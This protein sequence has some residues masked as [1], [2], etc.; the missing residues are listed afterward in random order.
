MTNEYIINTIKK[1]FEK[2][3]Y[4]FFTKGKYNVNLFGIRS[5]TRKANKFDDWF[6]LVYKDRHDIWK[7]WNCP[8][9]TDTGSFYLKNPMRKKGCLI[10]APQQ[11]R[12]GYQIGYHKGRLALVQIK[13]F[14]GYRDNNRDDILNF[15]RSTLELDYFGANFHNR[16]NDKNAEIRKDSGGCQV[17]MYNADHSD[18]M[19]IICKASE[20]WGD[21]FTYT[22]F[23]EVDFA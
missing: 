10:L 21:K 18:A 13:P 22:L 5:S 20:S 8:G 4:A 14:Y 17:P 19:T 6:Y 23:D 12:G 3:D 7:I 16:L 1:V 11:I 2:H 15:D 9:T